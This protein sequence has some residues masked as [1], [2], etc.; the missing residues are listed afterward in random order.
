MAGDIVLVHADPI[1]RA[2]FAGRAGSDTEIAEVDNFGLGT[3]FCCSFEY[4]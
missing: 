2:A 4:E 3:V 1:E